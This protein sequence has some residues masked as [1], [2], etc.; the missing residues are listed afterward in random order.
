MEGLDREFEQGELLGLRAMMEQVW[1][2][3]QGEA[4]RG[5]VAQIVLNAVSGDE[6]S[7]AFLADNYGI[8][9][10]SAGE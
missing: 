5:E 8:Q 2:A 1:M 6:P 4:G 7:I 3:E 9:L 10:P